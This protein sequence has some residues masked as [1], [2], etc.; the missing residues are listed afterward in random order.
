MLNSKKNKFNGPNKTALES[1]PC[2]YNITAGINLLEY[3]A[4]GIV[5]LLSSQYYGQ[6]K[7]H[8]WVKIIFIG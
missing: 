8:M 6:S 4:K 3:D 2:G 1:K 5:R 7:F